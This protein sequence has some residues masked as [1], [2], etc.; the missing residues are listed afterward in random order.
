MDKRKKHTS[1]DMTSRRT[2]VS[3]RKETK[4]IRG[5]NSAV[6]VLKEEK[7]NKEVEFF[8]DTLEAQKYEIKVSKDGEEYYAY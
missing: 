1:K 8:Q 3:K 6:N 4:I 2:F 5:F 7:E